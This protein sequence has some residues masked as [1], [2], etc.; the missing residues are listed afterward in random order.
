MQRV[1]TNINFAE[2]TKDFVQSERLAEPEASRQSKW[3][4]TGRLIVGL[5]FLYWLRRIG[6]RPAAYYIPFRLTTQTCRGSADLRSNLIIDSIEEQRWDI[7][8]L[9]GVENRL[10]SVFTRISCSNVI[11]GICL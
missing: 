11:S 2:K 8:C 7:I 4:P 3:D 9:F 10:L 5:Y 6:V 1:T